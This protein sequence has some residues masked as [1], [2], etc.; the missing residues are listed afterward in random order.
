IVILLVCA[1]GLTW[2]GLYPQTFLDVSNSSMAWLANS[3]IPV[4]EAVDTVQ[5]AAIQLE[6]VEIQ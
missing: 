5:Q 3:Y 4:Q 1:L 2:L 6:N